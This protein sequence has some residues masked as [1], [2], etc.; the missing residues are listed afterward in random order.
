MKRRVLSRPGV[1]SLM[2]YGRL[3]NTRPLQR[4]PDERLLSSWK[5]PE[6]V[7][8]MRLNRGR[9]GFI[10]TTIDISLDSQISLLRPADSLFT[11][12]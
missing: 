10:K 8:V 6:I 9:N 2:S 3:V 11:V 12:F 1:N 4:F 7:K 5:H